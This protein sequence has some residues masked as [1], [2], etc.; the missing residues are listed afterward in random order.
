MM[1]RASRGFFLKAMPPLAYGKFPSALTILWRDYSSSGS[2]TNE[3]AEDESIEKKEATQTEDIKGGAT[4]STPASSTT[5]WYLS[6]VDRVE[7]Q[8][9]SISKKEDIKFP[10]DSPEALIKITEYLRDELGLTNILLF[11]LRDRD[12]KKFM[13]AV[14]KISDFMIIGTAKSAKHC[15][16]SFVLLNSLMKQ[17]YNSVAYVEGN[18]N[19]KDEKKRQKRLAR[20]A[21]L[22]KAWGSNS[23]SNSISF[24]N[25]S[26]A[27]FMIDCHVDGIFVNIVT[28]KRRYEL[29]LEELYAPEDERSKY[30]R[31]DAKLER[32][33]EDTINEVSSENNV[34]A[35]LRRLAYQ[36]RQYSTSIPSKELCCQLSKSLDEEN[37]LAARHVIEGSN[38]RRDGNNNSLALPFMQTIV[39][40][41]SNLELSLD[42]KIKVNRWHSLF[43]LC[44]PLVLPQKSAPM[45]WSLRFK[46]LEL[47]NLANAKAYPCDKFIDDYLLAKKSL[48]FTLDKEDLLQFLK[49][50]I[51]N[52]YLKTDANYWDLVHSNGYVTNALKLFEDI[53][54]C[55]IVDDELVVSVL[56]RTMVLN[57]DKRTRLHS[58]Y[59]V[60]DHIVTINEGK[61][62]PNMIVI[63][64]EILGEIK[65]WNKF[66]QVWEAG[67]KGVVPRQDYR[68]WSHFLRI[69]VESNDIE[70]MQKII[71]E[72]HLLWL[73]RY[74][75]EMSEEIELQLA[76]LFKTVDPQNVAFTEL[77]S[78]ICM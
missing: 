64:L 1:L 33:S 37:F 30:Q 38:V 27:W 51:N 40:S 7:S 14:A 53:N 69:I 74:E 36:R 35:G 6:M 21:N 72:D 39:N 61:L 18:I 28:E 71:N 59:E 5:P 77:R 12:E 10:K 65:D 2:R 73:K 16:K 15:Q 9:E 66:L 67:I 25:N 50:V 4:S 34:L 42:T 47:L 63:L 26:E 22:S 58:L 68:P 23:N 60:I 70:F 8:N 19:P 3:F 49:I 52:L 11:D 13:T 48:G 31:Q 29:N 24:Q 43:E 44:W 78:F 17:E 56:L 20:K 55:N 76:R 45:Y 62:S 32:E 54:G 41:F 75:V 46:F 57:D